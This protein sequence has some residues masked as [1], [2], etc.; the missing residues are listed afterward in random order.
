MG[1]KLKVSDEVRESFPDLRLAILI[2]TG[3]DNSGT[4]P[5]LEDAKKKAAQKFREEWSYERLTERPEIQA[6]REAYR[7]FGVKYK[8]SRPTAEAF[9]RR[10]IKD[11]A[12]PT[13]SKAVDSYLLTETEYFLPVGGYDLDTLSGDIV[14]RVSTGNE[15]FIPIGGAD[16]EVTREGEVI[17]SDNMRV[18]TRKWNFRDCD[19]CKITTDSTNIVLVSE[20]PFESVPI[21]HLSASIDHMARTIG[22]YCGG[23][24]STQV[25]EACPE[26]TM[27]A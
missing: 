25:M 24:I 17:Y 7:Q 20:A 1:F 11:E 4:D 10:L 23:T 15:P 6:W 13:I 5:Q 26:L 12:F 3:I 18:L 14:L 16:T 27:Q 9:L 22:E 2:A 8:S 21:E 19:H